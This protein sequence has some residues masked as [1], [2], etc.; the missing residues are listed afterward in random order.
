MLKSRVIQ[1][2]ELFMTA[3]NVFVGTYHF[4]S[5]YTTETAQNLDV[6]LLQNDLLK[7]QFEITLVSCTMYIHPNIS[8]LPL[9]Y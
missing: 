7:L 2:N 8:R 4:T 6:R 5:L 9:Y 3:K 1:K